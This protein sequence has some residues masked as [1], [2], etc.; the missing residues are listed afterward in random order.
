MTDDELLA[1]A[2]RRGLLGRCT[3]CR[4]RW[5][6]RL[7]RWDSDGYALRCAGCLRIPARCTCR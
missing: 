5:P 3:G 1:E 2:V 4:R 7:C 6:L